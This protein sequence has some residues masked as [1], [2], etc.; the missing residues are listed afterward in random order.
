M[1]DFKVNESEKIQTEKRKSIWDKWSKL[2][3]LKILHQNCYEINPYGKDFNYAK[4]FLS[5]DIESVKKDI[6]ELMT[7][8]QDW[9]PADFGHYGGYLFVW[10]GILLVLIE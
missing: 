10:H 1:G 9:W 7:Q 2:L 4:E 6:K 3:N 5:L 8:S